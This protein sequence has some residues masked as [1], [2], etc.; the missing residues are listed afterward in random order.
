MKADR[1]QIERALDSA[2]GAVRMFLLHGPDESG[3]RDLAGRLGQALGAGAERIE[4]TGAALKADPARLADEAAAM[5]LFGERRYIRVEPAG[6]EIIGA[7]EALMEA[8]AAGNPVV[9]IAGTLRNSKLLKLALAHRAALAFASYLPDASDAGRLVTAI[10]RDHGLDIRGDVA[11]RIAA[12]M[13]GDRALIGREIEKLALFVDAAPDR[14][15]ELDHAALDALGAD[16]D[17]GDLGRLVGA[18]L[19]GKLADAEAELGRLGG[20]G[21]DGMALVRTMLRRLHQLAELR[22]VVADGNSVEAAMEKAGKSLFW[23]DKATISSELARWRPEAIGIAIER[24]L[25]AERELK[26]GGSR[27]MIAVAEEFLSVG[28]AAAR[29]R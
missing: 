19:G 27:G 28:R 17:E 15:A 25:E 29:M 5:S 11:Q 8:S 14:R 22:A 10:G 4:L 23:R 9:V 16:F 1:G 20:N 24:L 2:A 12:A 18:V 21:A 6:D 13:G 26:R 7:V 3:S